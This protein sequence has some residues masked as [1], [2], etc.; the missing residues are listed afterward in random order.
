MYNYLYTQFENLVIHF[1][2]GSIIRDH[3]SDL[4]VGMGVVEMFDYNCIATVAIHCC[5]G[6]NFAHVHP[7]CTFGYGRLIAFHTCVP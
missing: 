2:N 6:E 1:P 7:H 4:Y 3:G 5:G